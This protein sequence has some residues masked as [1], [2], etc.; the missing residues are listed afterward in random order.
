M[1]CIA[2]LHIYIYIYIYLA[3]LHAICTKCTGTRVH[4]CMQ[5]CARVRTHT[6]STHI[7]AHLHAPTQM[8]IHMHTHTHTHT[9]THMIHACTC[10][11]YMGKQD[12]DHHHAVHFQHKTSLGKG[13]AFIRF[14][15][16]HQRLA[17]SLQQC[18]I[19]PKTGYELAIVLYMLFIV[20]WASIGGCGC[21]S[22]EASL[23]IYFKKMGWG[24]GVSGW[25]PDTQKHSQ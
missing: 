22:A 8:H 20:A 6:H 16:V 12:T 19:H 3:H 9:H 11:L 2:L 4:A 17:D 18:V 15:L 21:I 14:A 5:M 10:V 7:Y 1:L 23:F 13:R 25:D 24:G